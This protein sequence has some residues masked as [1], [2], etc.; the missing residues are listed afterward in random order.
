MSRHRR[1]TRSLSSDPPASRHVDSAAAGSV[2][3]IG[4]VHRGR[5][6]PYSG[7]PRTRPMKDRVREAVFNLLGPDVKGK[8]VLD[9][10]AG[11]GVLGLEALSRGAE[12]AV[13]FERHFPTADSIQASAAMLG[14]LEKCEII[15]AN[16]LVQFRKPAPFAPPPPSLSWVVFCSPPFDLYVQQ[17]DE[18]VRLLRS[19]DDRSPV[20]SMIVVESDE[21]FEM[22]RLPQAEQWQVRDYPPARIAL[23]RKH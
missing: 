1:P 23:W 16:T 15:P 4:G 3:I 13:F 9:L 22:N 10:F 21:R 2:R 11:T 7:D 8:L 20:G 14:L 12:R 6:I 5:T 17:P 19:I 18:I